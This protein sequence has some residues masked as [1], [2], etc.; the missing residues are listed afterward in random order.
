MEGA[1]TI[2]VTGGRIDITGLEETIGIS[3]T[4]MWI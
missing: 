3:V 2:T 4:G 1:V